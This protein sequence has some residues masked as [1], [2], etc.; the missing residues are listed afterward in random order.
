MSEVLAKPTRKRDPVATRAK[1]LE[2]AR[3]AFTEK[4]YEGAGLRE[5]CRNAGVDQALVKRYFG[6]KEALFRETFDTG[7]WISDM[8]AVP[9]EELGEA[10]AD[11]WINRV[12][13]NH[14]FDATMAL[15]RSVGSQQVNAQLRD[16]VE[17]Q[18]I[19]RLAAILGGR[20][21]HQRAAL[22]ISQIIGIDTSRRILG[23]DA[24]SDVHRKTVRGLWSVQIQ[25]L[26]DTE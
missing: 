13:P 20:N 2:S 12:T 9:R 14:G 25:A 18:H 23:V 26:V 11:F 24:M 21:A 19:N 4:G 15:L 10:I 16:V 6:S 3:I 5:I 8:Q 22:I 1:L 7:T 17:N